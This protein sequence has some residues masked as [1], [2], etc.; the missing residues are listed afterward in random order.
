[1]FTGQ[2]PWNGSKKT[3]TN[4]RSLLS[5]GLWIFFRI[6]QRMSKDFT[7]YTWDLMSPVETVDDMTP[8]ISYISAFDTTHNAFNFSPR[9]SDCLAY[10]LAINASFLPRN[11]TL[12]NLRFNQIN[13]GIFCSAPLVRC[14][15]S[16]YI[17]YFRV[18]CKMFSPH[19]LFFLIL[20]GCIVCRNM[21]M[22]I[23]SYF[24]FSEIFVPLPSS[25]LLLI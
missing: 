8:R 19:L 18:L 15:S 14:S 3:H 1:M 10:T 2:C 6:E 9:L 20:T 17:H 25:L 4:R 24:F 13:Q 5:W 11:T 23:N 22:W 7:C 12:Q 21:E 16:S